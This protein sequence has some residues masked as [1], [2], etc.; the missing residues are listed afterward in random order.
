VV[1]L[2]SEGLPRGEIWWTRVTLGVQLSKKE[3]CRTEIEVQLQKEV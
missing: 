1:N 3:G 2:V